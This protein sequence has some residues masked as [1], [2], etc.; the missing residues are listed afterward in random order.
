MVG[1]FPI[2]TLY[3]SPWNKTLQ[4]AHLM[5]SNRSWPARPVELKVVLSPARLIKEGGCVDLSMDTLHLRYPL[6]LFGS[7]GSALLSPRMIVLSLLFNND[8][9]P[10]YANVVW[11]CMTFVCRCAFKHLFIHSSSMKHN[12]AGKK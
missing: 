2:C 12:L 5:V 7:K 3:S 6:V 4:V 11:H 8:K 9:G 10:L 1:I